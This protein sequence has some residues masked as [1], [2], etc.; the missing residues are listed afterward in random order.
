M[1]ALKGNEI[2]RLIAD[3]KRLS[4]VIL[5]YGPDQ[6]LVAERSA[7]IVRAASAGVDDPFSTVRLDGAEVASDP[8]RLDDEARTVALFGGRRV[9][10][11]RDAGNRAIEN[12]VRP[13]LDTPPADAV[14]V[15]EAGDLKKGTGLRKR[16]EDHRTAL[17]VPC[18]ADAAA[19]LD[20]V[21]AEEAKAAG[22]GVDDDARQALHLLLGA[23]RRLTRS[24][25][26]KLCLYARG[27]G[28]VTLA[29]V[30]AIVGDTGAFAL[31]DAIDAALTG[32]VVSLEREMRRIAASG[33]HPSVL[34]TAALRQLQTLGRGRLVVDAGA[35]PSQA[36]ERMVPPV[37][38]RRKAVVARILSL[39]PTA[40]L[41]AA[42]GRI[43]EAIVQSRLKPAL[44]HEIAAEALLALGTAAR[45]AGRR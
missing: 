44:G 17:A 36:V 12:A 9:V 1:V 32:D 31:D 42:A 30:R 35:T 15:I 26:V 43:D 37:F 2:D 29:D 40:R 4:G 14:V 28:R 45:A 41:E 3:P 24:E 13:L 6:G 11:V 21:I 33:T 34:L 25:I 23:D 5:V 27:Q 18:Y 39:W 16:V 7:A 10:W 19:D 22:L 38:F 8:A 20:R